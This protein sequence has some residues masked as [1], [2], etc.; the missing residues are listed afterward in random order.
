MLDGKIRSAMAK[1]YDVA[2]NHLSEEVDTA[3]A[4]TLNDPAE[5]ENGAR[6]C[7]TADRAA[8]CENSNRKNE[9]HLSTHHVA[10]LTVERLED[11]AGEEESGSD[12]REFR[13]KIQGV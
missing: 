4:K 13:P 8:N 12:P 11:G 10:E 7:S 9:R 5:D 3:G 2:E 1:W 6:M